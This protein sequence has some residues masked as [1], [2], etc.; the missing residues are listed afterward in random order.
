MYLPYASFREKTSG[1]SIAADSIIRT[2]LTRP[3]GSYGV[4]VVPLVLL[5]GKTT[6]NGIV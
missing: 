4:K 3:C 2:A 1:D 5:V 6:D